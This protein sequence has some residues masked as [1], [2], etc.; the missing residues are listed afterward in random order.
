MTKGD[1][2]WNLASGTPADGA[3]IVGVLNKLGDVHTPWPVAT[4]AG[5]R[6]RFEVTAD[7]NQRHIRM[8][9]SDDAVA[10]LYL[11]TSPGYRRVHAR[12]V[13]ADEVFSIDFA[14]FEAPVAADDWLDK[15]LLAAVGDVAEVTLHGEWT[16]SKDAEGWHL[17]V[18][19]PMQ[20]GAERSAADPEAAQNLVDRISGL[21][22]TG[23]A[24]TDGTMTPNGTFTVTDD[25]GSNQL[26][27]YHD[28]E[29]DAYAIESDRTAG[30]FAISAYIAE[31]MIVAE[32]D[33]RIVADAEEVL[34][35]D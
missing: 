35:D 4:S 26:R 1:D 19:V 31:Q 9:A 32:Q 7:S 29:E 6:A 15:N 30:R 5:S 8:F 3:K 22:V 13:D 34:P 25:A 33:L 21:R 27:I 12:V 23:F 11:G 10:D 14:N 28:A 20:S 2:G 16:L 17:S 18:A 24:E